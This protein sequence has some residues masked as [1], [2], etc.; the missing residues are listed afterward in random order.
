MA[1]TIQATDQMAALLEAFAAK[2]GLDPAE[3]SAAMPTTAVTGRKTAPV[4]TGKAKSVAF[5]ADELTL[6]ASEID[7]KDY[8]LAVISQPKTWK[9]KESGET[10]SSYY[11]HT[12]YDLMGDFVKLFPDLGG[13]GF[14]ETMKAM[15]ADKLIYQYPTRGGFSVIA[16]DRRPAKGTTAVASDGKVRLSPAAA[17]ALANLAK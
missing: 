7:P 17:K 9:D 3:V 10:R 14:V 8:I 12:K 5:D 1:K 11:W 6:T 15:A 13:L 16:A 4:A 2:F